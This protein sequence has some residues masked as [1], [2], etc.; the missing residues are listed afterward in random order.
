MSEGR[1]TQRSHRALQM[2]LESDMILVTARPLGLS[3]HKLI[4]ICLED[5]EYVVSY[6]NEI[7]EQVKE[8]ITHYSPRSSSGAEVNSLNPSPKG[9]IKTWTLRS[10][11]DILNSPWNT[12][13]FRTSH[14]R[15]EAL[16]SHKKTIEYGFSQSWAFPTPP[17]TLKVFGNHY[18]DRG[19]THLYFLASNKSTCAT[20][21]M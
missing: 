20:W 9:F 10:M 18:Q 1:V 15:K 7:E 5:V 6:D 8:R 17:Q 3:Q 13:K 21:N 2:G 19:D 16:S 14:P 12:K 4:S 11:R